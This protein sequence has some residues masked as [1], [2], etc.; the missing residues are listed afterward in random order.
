MVAIEQNTYAIMVSGKEHPLCDEANALIN[1]SLAAGE[2]TSAE[3]LI[4]TIINRAMLDD[5][6][7]KT[8]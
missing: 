8:N 3:E 7:L 4:H 1:T 6:N 5:S 2:Y